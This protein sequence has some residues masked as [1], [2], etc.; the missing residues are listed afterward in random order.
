MSNIEL[1]RKI[2]DRGFNAG[3]LSVA[4][5]VCSPQLIE[6]EYLVPPHL[7]GADILKFQIETARKEM[8][9]LRL[10]IEDH[11]ESG[12]KVWVRM[13]GTGTDPR[14]SRT[15]GMDVIDICRFESGKLV[16]HWGV[17]DRFALL[18]QSGALP[19]RPA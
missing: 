8:Q 19:P 3:D 9:G 16:E 18:H 5:E 13:R 2:I 10:M 7:N 11:V 15:I 6:R 12:Q 14:S 17:P 1:F 4:D